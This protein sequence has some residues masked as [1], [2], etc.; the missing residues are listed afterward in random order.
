MKRILIAEG[1]A[2]N[3]SL[4]IVPATLGDGH[5]KCTEE[6]WEDDGIRWINVDGGHRTAAVQEVIED[7]AI[8]ERRTLFIHV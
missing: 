6:E 4:I 3:H 5:L 7:V 2:K 1:F 8:G